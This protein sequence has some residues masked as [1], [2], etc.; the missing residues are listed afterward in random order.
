MASIS[1]PVRAV[2]PTVVFMRSTTCFVN[3]TS[4]P[5]RHRSARGD[6]R[7]QLGRFLAA[8]IPAKRRRED[9]AL[10]H[11]PFDDQSERCRG[12][13]HDRLG[14]CLRRVAP[15]RRHHHPRLPLMVDVRELRD[16]ARWHC[17][18]LSS[19]SIGHLLIAISNT[20]I[21]AWRN[22]SCRCLRV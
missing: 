10:P 2:V 16:C 20:L 4:N 3:P 7:Y 22:L 21:T 1:T 12:H 6:R 5:G 11:L 17:V 14:D 19:V 9:I 18:L 8:M 15:S 13:C